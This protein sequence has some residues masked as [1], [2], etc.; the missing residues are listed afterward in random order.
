MKIGI[1]CAMKE[2]FNLIAQDIKTKEIIKKTNLEFITGKLHDKNVVGVICGIGKVNSAICTQILISEFKCTHILNS[3]VAGGLKDKI[4][5]K[6]IV[7]S[8][9][10][11]Q[12]DV[13]LCSF[14]YKMGEIPNIGTYSF[15]SDNSLLNLAEKICNDISKYD[16][17]FKFHIG[18]IITGDQFIDND[19]I[20]KDLQNKFD[21]IACEMESGSIAQTCYLNNIPF[22]V[23]RSISDKAGD[24]AKKD[25]K[26]FLEEAAKN[27]YI[28]VNN[29]V[30]NIT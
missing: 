13:N 20:S 6:D 3:G 12:H 24:I 9:D 17:I 15:K 5:Y 16:K 19:K 7:L 25:F 2:E 1:I 23:I 4:K 29:L 14:G 18:R 30:K 28:I 11:I 26:N 27:S 10:L 21:A 8:K 22:L